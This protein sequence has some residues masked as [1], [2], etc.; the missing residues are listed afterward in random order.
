MSS[1]VLDLQQEVLKPDCDILSA[2]RKAHLIAAKLKLAEFDSWIMSELNG[3]KGGQLDFPQYRIVRGVLK[4][5]NPYNGWIPVQFADNK[6]RLSFLP[7]SSPC[8]YPKL[9]N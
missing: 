7:E 3:Y 1:L 6:Q 9:S 4:A 2:L 8:Q 5:R